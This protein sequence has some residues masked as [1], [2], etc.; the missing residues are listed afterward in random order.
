MLWEDKLRGLIQ[1]ACYLVG[2]TWSPLPNNIY[3]IVNS[4]CNARCL[5]CDIG[6]KKETTFYN[7]MTKNKEMSMDLIEKTI[8]DFYWKPKI[9]ITSTE[10]LL[11][12]KIEDAIKLYKKS[13]FFVSITTNGILLDKYIEAVTQWVDELVISI[14]GPPD[15]NDKIRGI[16]SSQKIL[17]TIKRLRETRSEKPRI[18]INTVIMPVNQDHIYD[19]LKY[20][21]DLADFH[22]LSHMNYVSESCSRKHNE[23]FPQYPMTPSAIF[24]ISPSDIDVNKLNRELERALGDFDF[25]LIPRIYDKIS[26]STYYKEPE[27]PIKQDQKCQIPWRAAQITPNGDVLIST[28]CFDIS[29]GNIREKS[30]LEIWNGEKLRKFRKDLLQY[31]YFLVCNRC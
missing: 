28:R 6:Q 22:V 7:I 23:L 19:T 9:R 17:E 3:L 11:Y 8:K 30:F 31:K 1:K 10:P 16:K 5:M 15:V 4:V 26:L 20:Y 18:G 13:N 12:S 24:G 25:I 14:D 27:K 21:R 29:M 2:S